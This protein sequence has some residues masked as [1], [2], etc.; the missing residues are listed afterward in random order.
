[1]RRPR[2]SLYTGRRIGSKSK[3]IDRYLNEEAR[4]I[5]AVMRGEEALDCGEYLSHEQM[6]KRLERLL[7]P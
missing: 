3:A 7:Q 1:V 6:G 4:F 5:K 2:S